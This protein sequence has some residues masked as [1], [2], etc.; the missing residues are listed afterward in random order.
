MNL[1]LGKSR[2]VAAIISLAIWLFITNPLPAQQK[3]QPQV[4]DWGDPA[5]LV[6]EGNKTFK[7]DDIRNALFQN[8]DVLED[9]HPLAPLEDYRH[10]LMLKTASGYLRAGFAHVKVDV[11]F[12]EAT[13]HV[14]LTIDEGPR[15]VCGNIAVRGTFSFPPAQIE[16]WLTTEQPPAGTVLTGFSG[17]SDKQVP[18]WADTS[19]QAVKLQPPTWLRGQ[20]MRFDESGTKS[21]RDDVKRAL[22][23]LGCPWAEFDVATPLDEATR[24]ANLEINIKQPGPLAVVGHINVVGNQRDSEQDVLSYLGIRPGMVLTESERTRLWYKL[25]MSGR[26]LKHDVDLIAPIQPTG[27]ADL[28]ITLTEYDQAPPLAKPL[29]PVE[30]TLMKCREWILAST[31]RGDDWVWNIEGPINGRIIISSKSGLLA[32]LYP[33]NAEDKE[34]QE[35]LDKIS[36]PETVLALTPQNLLY[37]NSLVAKKLMLPCGH[38][39]LAVDLGMCANVDPK[40]AEHHF[41]TTFGTGFNFD[42]TD[43]SPPVDM[44]ITVSPVS[45]FSYRQLN[46]KFAISGGIVVV[47]NSEGEEAARIEMSTGRPLFLRIAID[48]N[49]QYEFRLEHD[50]FKKELALADEHLQRRITNN[51]NVFDSQRPI[52]S[53]ADFLMKDPLIIQGLRALARDKQAQKDVTQLFRALRKIIAVGLFK[54]LDELAQSSDGQSANSNHES[55]DDFIIPDEYNE[56]E[57]WAQFYATLE[58]IILS[59]SDTNFPRCSAA[60]TIERGV[61]FWF[62]QRTKFLNDDARHLCV[63]KDFGPLGHYLLAAAFRSLQNTAY[64]ELIRTYAQDG[65]NKLDNKN[66]NAEMAPLLDRTKLCG[67]CVYHVADVLQQIDEDDATVLGSLFLGER[68]DLLGDAARRLRQHKE[69]PIETVL[70]AVLDQMWTDGLKSIVQQ[71]LQELSKCGEEVAQKP[72]EAAPKSDNS[73]PKTNNPTSKA[74]TPATKTGESNQFW[75]IR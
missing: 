7:T 60:W 19:G 8:F 38:C 49:N 65:L 29:T 9:G 68:G 30:Q 63:Q 59:G 69:Q 51:E 53:I 57:G 35:I 27:A 13:Q 33:H 15:F 3:P 2:R 75:R 47:T 17:P 24:T 58:R 32:H 11:R 4:G 31:E 6:I 23:E 34:S 42:V 45:M 66:F 36:W 41:Q 43:G 1:W 71:R 39:Q 48:S 73:T 70:P 55:G 18:Q 72:E 61:G 44:H 62:S 5:R 25:W 50:A 22:A 54:P 28:Q 56:H 10:T 12:D 16:N 46:F 52:T 37:A 14:V 26:Y 21:L 67:K 74:D 40:D 64:Y 20:S